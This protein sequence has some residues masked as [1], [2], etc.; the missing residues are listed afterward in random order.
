[1]KLFIHIPL[2]ILLISSCN[3]NPTTNGESGSKNSA[4]INDPVEVHLAIDRVNQAKGVYI[5]QPSLQHVITPTSN[6]TFVPA[7]PEGRIKPAVH[8]QTDQPVKEDSVSVQK[9][10]VTHFAPKVTMNKSSTL[11]TG[12]KKLTSDDDWWSKYCGGED[13]PIDVLER[14]DASQTPEKW[15]GKCFASK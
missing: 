10:T 12:V 4:T 3:H 14:L 15:V 7:K 8:R 11:P 1:M 2:T 13:I 6:Q 9:T 5:Q